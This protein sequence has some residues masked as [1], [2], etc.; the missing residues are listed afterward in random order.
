MASPSRADGFDLAIVGG[1]AAGCVLARRLAE[2][3]DRR[4]VLIEAG[5]DLR[6]ATP[7]ELLDGWTL[8]KPPDWGFETEAD[9]SGTTQKLRRG[10]LLG[11]TSWLTR[12]AV[13][14]AAADFDAWA[15]AGNLGWAFADVLPAF[16]RL[17]ADAEFGDRPWHGDR[18]PM[19]I[20]RYLDHAPSAAHAAA[21]AA[22]EASGFARVDDHNAPDAV[23]VGRMPMSSRAGVR[24][25]SVDAYLPPDRPLEN[26]TI[27]PD[28]LVDRV[29]LEGGRAAAVV[30]ADGSE[31]RADLI[32]LAAGTY[33]SPSILMRSG[34]GP[35][36][37]LRSLGI[38][39]SVDLPGVGQN[40][41]DHPGVDLDSGWSGDGTAGPVT[42]S[43]ATFR[44]N[45][46]PGPG[47]D[48][49]FWII[50][51]SGDEPTLYLDPILLQPQSRGS[52]R[53]RTPDP[54]DPPRIELPGL[55][56]DAD[57]DRMV[58]G[59]LR[60]VELANHLAF[61]AAAGGGTAP[62]DPGGRAATRAILLENLYSN[63]HVVGTCAMGPSAAD[64]AVVDADGR[65]HG[66]TGL[67]VADASVIPEPPS[68]FP[69]VITLMLAEHLA[70]RLAGGS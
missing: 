31:I 39:V 53:L 29:R 40:L 18:G 2:S 49:M 24:A 47:P 48:M 70:G 67:A 11:G 33:G 69:H 60:G 6:G 25:T 54:A 43:I 8:A 66:V 15:A 57:V 64:G 16:R 30:L 34:I 14:G 65:V 59:Y 13:R 27:R 3:G 20:T 23:G 9:A 22:L 42:H 50:D 28:S 51:P 37:Q 52:V 5:P 36:G 45:L 32:V 1:G 4:V 62:S 61:R 10:R 38:G 21:V 63:P 19:P 46:A 56:E 7:P 26:L 55:R 58:D 41:A 12:F 17:E 35:A 44:S 68:G